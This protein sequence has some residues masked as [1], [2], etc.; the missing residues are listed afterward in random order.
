MLGFFFDPWYFIIV[1]PFALLAWWASSRVKGTFD[2]FNQV[3]IRSGYSGHETAQAML[4]AAGLNDVG[5]ESVPG[6]LSDHYDPQARMVRLS[7]DILYGRSAAAVAV[8]AHEVGHALQHAEG[9]KAM[10]T[11]SA[12]V[13]VVNIG[14]QLAFPLLIVGM[15]LS[16]PGLAWAGVIAFGAAV[17]FH[18]V[19]LP[20]EYDASFR[21]MRI[22]EQ[23]GIVAAEE[24]PGVKKTLYSAGF[25]YVAATLQSVAT[26]AYFAFHALGTS[27]EE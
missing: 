4:R 1:G 25:T 14:S 9:Y 7:E 24:M 2:R 20:V 17:L 13:P 21:A 5:I 22:L 11:R 26:L 8:A 15:I 6:M 16:S 19:T 18:L 23:S 12:L 10:E 3:P 27:R